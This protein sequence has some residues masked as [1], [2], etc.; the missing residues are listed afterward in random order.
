VIAYNLDEKAVTAHM[1]GWE[2]DP[3]E[4]EVTQ[5]A[6][7]TENGPLSDSQT[8]TETFE[9]SRDIAITFPPRT[10]TVLELK[11]VKKGVPYWSRP[12]LGIDRDDVKVA[13]GSMKVTVHSLGAVDAPAAM[14]VVRDRA[15]KVLAQVKTPPLKAPL[16]LFP[17]TATATLKLPKKADLTGGSVTIES[18]GSVP[19]ITQLNN[20][21]PL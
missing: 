15:G 8:H 12:D 5:S 14:V 10:T 11:L 18:N 6:Q 9:R 1:T 2:I 19:E 13:N 21:V 4:W 17:K 20:R 3:G 16:D 7:A